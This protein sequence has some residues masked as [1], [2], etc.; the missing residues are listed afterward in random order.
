MEVV[1]IIC[2][3][4]PFHNGH[5]YHIK[6]IKEL[7]PDSLTI[8]A[9]NGYFLERGEISILNKED[10]TRI[11][12]EHDVDLVVEIP[13]IFGTQS[14]DTFADKAIKILNNFHITKLVFGSESNDI[15]KLREIACNQLNLDN[16]DLV[17]EYLDQGINYPTALAKASKVDFNFLPNDLLAI[18]YLKTIIK[19]DYNI[20]AITI[21]R[22]NDYHDKYS[23]DSIISATN[24]REKI[25]NNIDIQYYLPKSSQNSIIIPNDNLFFKLLKYKILTDNYLSEYLDVDEG[26]E[27]RLKK[28][29]T[30][31]NDLQTFIKL[32]KT[33]RYTYNKIN[34]MLIHILTNFK[35][36]IAK[37]DIEYIRILGFNKIGKN[38]I[39]AIKSELLIPITTNKNSIQYKYELQASLI[40]DLINDTNSF[41]YELKNKPIIID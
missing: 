14:A 19:N 36:D 17:K 26:I 32:I 21:K 40:F 5:I 10:K 1:G 8:L 37:I 33:K 4:N 9:V 11:A 16:S 6:K 20:D 38:Y 25:R 31:V 27:N 13:F 12:L 41:E 28:A 7:Y 24:I 18:S 22:T 34:R 29:I 35:K 39:N 30:E 2:E 23:N 3:Y 15:V